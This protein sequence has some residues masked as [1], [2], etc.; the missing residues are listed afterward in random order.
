MNNA[1]NKINLFLRVS[2]NICRYCCNSLFDCFSG[3]ILLF[4]C[5]SNV[6]YVVVVIVFTL[7]TLINLSSF[8]FRNSF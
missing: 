2:S 7:N 3:H 1:L 6:I 5:D 4:P 8:C